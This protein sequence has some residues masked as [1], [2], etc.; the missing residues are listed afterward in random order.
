[1]I[2]RFFSIKSNF[3]IVI[4]NKAWDKMKDITTKQ[5]KN[6]FLFS[7]KS[8]GCNGYNY[9]LKL[10]NKDKYENFI[11]SNGKVKPGIIKKNEVN[12]VIDPL[13]EMILL[14]TTIDYV[15]EDYEKGIYENKF[16]FKVNKNLASSCGCGISF[17]PK[18]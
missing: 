4:T 14:G 17:T 16:V 11:K 13:S 5:N 15:S 9:D 1:M 7:A 12:L 18:I 6:N 10:L 8:G 3:P 2:K